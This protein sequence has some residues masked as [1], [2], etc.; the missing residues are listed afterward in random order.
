MAKLMDVLSTQDRQENTVPFDLDLHC[1]LCKIV[2][3]AYQPH[4]KK[5]N[6][7]NMLMTNEIG[8]KT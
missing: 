5:K 7:S 2:C 8:L 1:F 6:L 3:I 4:K